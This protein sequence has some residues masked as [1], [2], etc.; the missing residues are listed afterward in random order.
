[1]K[2]SLIILPLAALL[3]IGCKGR[4]GDVT[5]SGGDTTSAAP[6]TVVPPSTGPAPVTSSAARPASPWGA[7]PEGNGT[8]ASPF[9]VTQAWD[10]VTKN[11]TQTAD[12]D[13]AKQDLVK[14]DVEY[15]VRGYVC[16]V[17]AI[18]DPSSPKADPNH[19]HAVKFHMADAGHYA[20]EDEVMNKDC[21]EGF[22]VY[23]ADTNPALESE[24]AARALAGKI[25]TVKGYLLNWKFEPEITSGGVIVDVTD[26]NA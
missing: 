9:N 10:Y 2:K 15:Y 19:P 25:V 16:Y 11:L 6:T 18:S 7:I 14:S 21:H 1:M 26:P 13:A 5:T 8:E 4:G 24:E 20:T 22:C 3:L 23:F 17:E 12:T